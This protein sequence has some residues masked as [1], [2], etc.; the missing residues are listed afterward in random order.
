MKQKNKYILPEPVFVDGIMELIRANKD[1]I[2][3]EFYDKM[4]T[5]S[6]GIKRKFLRIPQI[7]RVA[8]L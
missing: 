6:V 1:R 2:G 3:V 7:K 4:Q 8:A 5:K